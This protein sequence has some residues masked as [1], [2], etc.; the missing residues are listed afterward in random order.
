MQTTK[1]EDVAAHNEGLGFGAWLVVACGGGH[2]PVIM[3]GC[4]GLG[5]IRA[6]CWGLGFG[7]WGTGWRLVG[8]DAGA[9]ATCVMCPGRVQ[10]CAMG[11]LQQ[12]G[13]HTE[14]HT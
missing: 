10:Q 2:G 12:A 3:A 8:W 1:W 9:G 4:Y 6:G 14:G 7:V 5:V 11:S 13:W